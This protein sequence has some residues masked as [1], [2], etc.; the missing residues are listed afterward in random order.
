MIV[1]GLEMQCLL[2]IF[3]LQILGKNYSSVSAIC[4]MA[5][6]YIE[7]KFTRVRSGRSEHGKNLTRV[8]SGR[9]EHEKVELIPGKL[10]LFGCVCMY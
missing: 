6:Y 4:L 9:K 10:A 8:R 2:A 7:E 3:S 5:F 1:N